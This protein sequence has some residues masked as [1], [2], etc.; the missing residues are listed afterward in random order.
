MGGTWNTDGTR[1][2]L[3]VIAK[4]ESH[5]FDPVSGWCVHGCGNRQDGRQVTNGGTE[6]AA[7][8]EQDTLP[9]LETIEG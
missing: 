9:G 1:C 4:G 8:T 5:D 7:G 3:W 6:L 2:K